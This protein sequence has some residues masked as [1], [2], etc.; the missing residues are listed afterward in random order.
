MTEQE[1]GKLYVLWGYKRSRYKIHLTPLQPVN[2]FKHIVHQV[3]PCVSIDNSSRRN[4]WCLM[5]TVKH[6][7][8][9]AILRISPTSHQE[10]PSETLDNGAYPALQDTAGS[11]I[12]IMFPDSETP[13]ASLLGLRGQ[14]YKLK[15][16]LIFTFEVPISTVVQGPLSFIICIIV[17]T[18]FFSLRKMADAQGR[19]HIFPIHATAL[20]TSVAL[21]SH[22]VMLKQ[23]DLNRTVGSMEVFIIIPWFVSICDLERSLIIDL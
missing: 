4:H 14:I 10:I 5:A 18:P 2:G 7:V 1:T 15:V 12:P 23:F 21:L 19:T 22:P 13:K 17:A 6:P 3:F 8:N 9:L 20:S 11:S 16:G